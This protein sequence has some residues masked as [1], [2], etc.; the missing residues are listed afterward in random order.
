M[1]TSSQ[2]S[3]ADWKQALTEIRFNE[4]EITEELVARLAANEFNP[5]KMTDE[6]FQGSFTGASEE[7]AGINVAK[8][9]ASLGSMDWFLETAVDWS[10]AW[11]NIKSG[12]GYVLLPTTT[13]NNWSLF[14]KG[15][16]K[17]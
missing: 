6:S 1:F 12:E 16:Q 10:K 3:F 9:F 7:E 2:P 8:E 13:D 4:S 14:Y 5:M 15:N 17:G 11:Q